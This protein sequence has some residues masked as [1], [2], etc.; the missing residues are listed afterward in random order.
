[1]QAPP[2]RQQVMPPPA[3]LPAV[4]P[5][6]VQEQPAQENREELKRLRE[7]QAAEMEAAKQ[8]AADNKAL[9]ASEPRQ[10]GM[11]PTQP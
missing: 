10:R 9:E 11:R 1:M 6:P 8:A 7:Q 5:V 3:A 4:V 2:E